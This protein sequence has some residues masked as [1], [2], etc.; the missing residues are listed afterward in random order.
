MPIYK[1]GYV[2]S[3]ISFDASLSQGL[4]APA[5]SVNSRSFTIEFGFLLT[6]AASNTTRQCLF[7]VSTGGNLDIEFLMTIQYVQQ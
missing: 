1:T 6:N 7:L 3:A 4:S 5:M 2:G